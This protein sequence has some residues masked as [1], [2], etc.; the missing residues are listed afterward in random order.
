MS[1]A[2]VNRIGEIIRAIKIA[3]DEHE[4][5]GREMNDDYDQELK[6]R[7][8]QQRLSRTYEND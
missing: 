3:Q 6:N 5:G 7:A 2:D 1:Q 4:R 8:K